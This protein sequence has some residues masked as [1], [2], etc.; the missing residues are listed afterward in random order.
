[1]SQ[2]SRTGTGRKPLSGGWITFIVI[3]VILVLALLIA[4]VVI[5]SGGSGKDDPAVAT[6]PTSTQTGSETGEP[7]NADDVTAE[8]PEPEESESSDPTQEQIKIASPSGNIVCTITEDA[9]TCSIADLAKKP[10]KDKSC[11]GTVGYIYTVTED[12]VEAP[13]IA[14][15]QEPGKAGSGTEALDY[16]KTASA[17]GFTCTS[18][19]TGMGCAYDESGKGFSLARAGASTF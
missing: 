5:F 16:G 1:M 18:A 11:D 3:D 9:A 8:S 12:G 4:A 15:G 17:F 14:K 7:T 13:C 2:M 19:E 6:G 10:K